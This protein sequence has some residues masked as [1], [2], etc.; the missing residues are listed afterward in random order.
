M[1]LKYGMV[2]G[3]A[4]SFIGG[5]HR[6]SINLDGEAVLVA[7]SFSRDY[8]NTLATGRELGIAEDRLYK[9]YAGMAKAEAQRE[10]GIDFVV[11]VTPNHTHYAICKAF[12]EAG[13]HVSCDKPLAV[14]TG[15]AFELERPGRKTC[16]FW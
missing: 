12:L 11:V 9:S 8:E 7:G 4:G 16:S 14:N 10:D 1:R 2:G 3:G 15:Q 13:I 6:R 5:A